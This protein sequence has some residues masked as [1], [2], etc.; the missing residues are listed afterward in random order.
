MTSNWA[1][2]VLFIPRSPPFSPPWGC[3]AQG[4]FQQFRSLTHPHH[5]SSSPQ[6]A[7]RVAA[8]QSILW[9]S[10][11]T[12]GRKQR[13]LSGSN[14][15]RMFLPLF[16]HFYIAVFSHCRGR[17]LLATNTFCFAVKPCQIHVC[18]A[19]NITQT[20]FYYVLVYVLGGV[21][22]WIFFRNSEGSPPLGNSRLYWVAIH[23]G[24]RRYDPSTDIE[25]SFACS[26]TASVY[27]D[28]AY[29]SCMQYLRLQNGQVYWSI[30][31]RVEKYGYLRWFSLCTTN[32][33]HLSCMHIMITEYVLQTS[34]SVC[35]L[36]YCRDHVF[37]CLETKIPIFKNHF[38]MVDGWPTPFEWIIIHLMSDKGALTFVTTTS[39]HA[40][41]PFP[42]CWRSLP[43]APVYYI[44]HIH[45]GSE[46]G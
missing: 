29:G 46:N 41:F 18:M 5:N 6:L 19:Y 2:P 20:K 4:I 22:G 17:A 31:T 38:K 9:A 10:L 13:S 23:A 1:S 7:K 3:P 14:A 25:H 12:R 44:L 21:G 28:V 27:S 40:C 11:T 8:S 24:T 15:S 30:W 26:L 32:C 34:M 16:C 39:N 37:E 33:L 35:D 42:I 43:H 36:L 45:M